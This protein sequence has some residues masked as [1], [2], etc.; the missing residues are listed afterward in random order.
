MA[1]CG[2]QNTI[3]I[4]KPC[5]PV[6]RRSEKTTAVGAELD[7][8]D[9]AGMPADHGE[10]RAAFN[11]PDAGHSVHRRGGE[12]TV[13]RAECTIHVLVSEIHADVGDSTHF[14]PRTPFATRR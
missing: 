11:L 2:R 14:P 6:V 9:D 10:Q 7:V 12:E 8:L 4:P 1:Q 13:V 5:G 3:D